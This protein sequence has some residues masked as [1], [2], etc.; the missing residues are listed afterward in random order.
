MNSKSNRTQMEP[1]VVVGASYPVFASFGVT[2]I[3]KL[4]RG[5]YRSL[6]LAA[7]LIGFCQPGQ[8]QD[9]PG[10]APSTTFTGGAV[11]LFHYVL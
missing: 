3:R 9:A 5:L 7:L 10:G 6:V 2:R 1:V 11:T 4:K 8:A